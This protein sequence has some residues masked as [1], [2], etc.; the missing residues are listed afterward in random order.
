[1]HGAAFRVEEKT[2][3]RKE[4]KEAMMTILCT[5][6]PLI[7]QSKGVKATQEITASEGFK[8]VQHNF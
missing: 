6:S 3:E 1:M 2:A 4:G 7:T 8:P 5:V